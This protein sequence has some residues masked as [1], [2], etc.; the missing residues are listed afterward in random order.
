MT[1]AGPVWHRFLIYKDC[2]LIEV[3]WGTPQTFHA[4]ES[5]RELTFRTIE[6]V[7]YWLERKWP[8]ADAAH[9]IALTQV[10]AAMDCLVPVGSARSAFSEA[11]ASAGFTPRLS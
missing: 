7:A 11:A 6:H 5:G 4:P 10:H 1:P 8:V 3:Y 2:V 9:H